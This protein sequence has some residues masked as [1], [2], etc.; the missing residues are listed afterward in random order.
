MSPNVQ[1]LLLIGLPIAVV[2]GAIL[3]NRNAKQ[4]S[5]QTWNPWDSRQMAQYTSAAR[6]RMALNYRV[7][8]WL[9][10]SGWGTAVLMVFFPSQP[11]GNWLAAVA[12]IIGAFFAVWALTP[13]VNRLQSTYKQ[14]ARQDIMNWQ[15]LCP[16][17][18]RPHIRLL[19]VDVDPTHGTVTRYCKSCYRQH[20]R[21]MHHLPDAIPVITTW[22]GTI[23]F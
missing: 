19:Y 10:L 21:T 13:L 6:Q 1:I 20:I 3:F 14:L 11:P 5:R 17:C 23:A 12:L 18:A 16:S 7:R 15:P 9:P 2:L 8:R 22:S 4:R